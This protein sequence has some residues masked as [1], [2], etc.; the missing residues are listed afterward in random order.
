[1]NVFRKSSLVTLVCRQCLQLLGGI[2]KGLE[3]CN[4][5]RDMGK[6]CLGASSLRRVREV[7]MFLFDT[8]HEPY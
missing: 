8:S 1:M 7:E 6:V 5:N 2:S 4:P 3:T